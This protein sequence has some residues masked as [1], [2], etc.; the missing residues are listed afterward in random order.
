MFQDAVTQLTQKSVV[1]LEPRTV[2]FALPKSLHAVCLWQVGNTCAAQRTLFNA[3]PLPVL[4][5]KTRRKAIL[6]SSAVFL[7]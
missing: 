5:W 1:L 2:V 6:S 3:M 7:V 4:R